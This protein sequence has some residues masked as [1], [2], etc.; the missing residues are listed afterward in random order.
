MDKTEAFEI[1]APPDSVWSRWVKP[2]L[3]AEEVPGEAPPESLQSPPEMNLSWVPAA[4]R[5]TA[6]V[7]DLPGELSTNLGLALALRGYRPVPL[8]NSAP[9]PNA[10]VAVG[11]IQRLLFSTAPQLQNLALPPDAPPVFLLDSLRIGHVSLSPGRF[12][13]RWMIFPEDF[14]SANFLLGHGFG[15]VLL[16]QDFVGQP[17]RDLAHILLRWQQSRLSILVYGFKSGGALEPMTITR[18][19]HFR[20]IWYRA[21]VMAGLRRHSGGG[22]GAMIPDEDAEG[23]FG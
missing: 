22:F 14:P 11:G 4:A 16:V 10:L 2:V 3:F 12:D 6:I 8:Y 18:P 5:Q 13:N 15:C 21:L 23:G 19:N 20:K 1:W 17:Q 7:V 9:G